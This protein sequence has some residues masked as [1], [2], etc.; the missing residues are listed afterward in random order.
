[1]GAAAGAFKPAPRELRIRVPWEGPLRS[2]R[3]GAEALR[4]VAE[5]ELERQPSGFARS[6]GW[7]IV[8]LR[9]RPEAFQVTLEP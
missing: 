1:V 9:D 2:V 5:A 8:K 3:L 4:D 6:E 7:A